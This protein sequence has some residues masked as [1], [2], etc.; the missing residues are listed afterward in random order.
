MDCG[1][2]VEDMRVIKKGYE[3]EPAN[4]RTK[5]TKE[6]VEGIAD[7]INGNDEIIHDKCGEKVEDCQCPDAPVKLVKR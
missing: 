6:M 3:N 7:R 1:L 5:I 4:T 2:S